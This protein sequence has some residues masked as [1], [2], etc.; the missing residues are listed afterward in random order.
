MDNHR[1]RTPTLRTAR[2][3]PIAVSWHRE[4]RAWSRYAMP[5][6]VF[7]PVVVGFDA[8]TGGLLDAM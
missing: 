8:V 7:E 2:A 1:P 6:S 5:R 4:T 3:R